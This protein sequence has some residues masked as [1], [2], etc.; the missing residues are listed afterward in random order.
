LQQSLKGKE[1]TS[2]GTPGQAVFGGVPYLFGGM[3]FNSSFPLGSFQ[4]NS[5]ATA[6][7]QG[8]GCTHPT[9]N[10]LEEAMKLIRDARGVSK[11]TSP[12]PTTGNL[13]ALISQ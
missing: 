9:L 13:N 8:L 10:Y 6:L 2:G 7:N 1:G 12:A 5:S 11:S 3:P 4:S